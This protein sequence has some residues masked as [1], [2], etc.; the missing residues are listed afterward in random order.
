MKLGFFGSVSLLINFY[1]LIHFF[2]ASL[3]C[4]NLVFTINV[5]FYDKLFMMFLIYAYKSL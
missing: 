5:E 2:S 1:I 4:T 3:L